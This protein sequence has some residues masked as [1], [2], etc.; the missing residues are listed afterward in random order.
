M[1]VCM[2]MY[3][4]VLEAFAP[5]ITILLN[6]TITTSIMSFQV[7]ISRTCAQTI[8]QLCNKHIMHS[9]LYILTYMDMYLHAYG[10]LLLFVVTFIYKNCNIYTLRHTHFFCQHLP[11]KELLRHSCE[12]CG[13]CCWAAVPPLFSHKRYVFSVTFS[14]SYYVILLLKS[15]LKSLSCVCAQFCYVNT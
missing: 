15:K 3:A 11:L 2:C 5:K 9:Y 4:H 13:G 1:Y 8:Q 7:P 6:I 14:L 10:M 12:V